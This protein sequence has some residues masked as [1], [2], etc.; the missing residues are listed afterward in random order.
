MLSLIEDLT[1]ALR[2][3]RGRETRRV[4]A[5]WDVDRLV[6][7]YRRAD[8]DNDADA[9]TERAVALVDLQW[10]ACAIRNPYAQSVEEARQALLD[11]IDAA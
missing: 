4:I 6:T 3:E 10:S 5:R 11:A 2:A 9:A 8:A 7:A 1:D